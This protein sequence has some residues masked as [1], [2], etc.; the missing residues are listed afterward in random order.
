M[1]DIRNNN[2][3][4]KLI[5]IFIGVLLTVNPNNIDVY[6][7]LVGRC[8]YIIKIYSKSDPT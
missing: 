8:D 7:R 6:N 1:V 5:K 2:I 4:L 3:L